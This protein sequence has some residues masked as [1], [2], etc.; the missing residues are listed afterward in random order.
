[1]VN[2]V[3]WEGENGSPLMGESFG[4][5][6]SPFILFFGEGVNM[7][8]TARPCSAAVGVLGRVVLEGG[9]F[10]GCDSV[11]IGSIFITLFIVLELR[12]PTS[13]FTLM[14]VFCALLQLDDTDIEEC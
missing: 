10:S 14:L 6:G 4:V 8:D 11:S 2:F 3:T 13:D 7:G 12:L 5:P 1:M 9:W